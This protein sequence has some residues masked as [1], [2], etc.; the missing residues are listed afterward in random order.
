MTRPRFALLAASLGCSLAAGCAPVDPPD[1]AGRE[2]APLRATGV[3][4]RLAV[5]GGELTARAGQLSI[6]PG[7]GAI[8]LW[9]DAGLA[10]HGEHLL[11]ARAERIDLSA[12]RGTAVLLGRVRARLAVPSSA[13]EGAADAGR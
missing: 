4:L 10:L 1:P 9:G 7:G 5:D 3:T 12:D 13:A 8:A 6:E 11:E 2:P